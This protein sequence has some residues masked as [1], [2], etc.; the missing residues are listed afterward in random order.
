MSTKHMKKC[1]PSLTSLSIREMQAKAMLKFNLILEKMAI[2]RKSKQQMLVW[3][4]Q[5]RNHPTLLVGY[6]ALQ[7]LWESSRRC[8]KELKLGIPYDPATPLLSIFLEE[9]K[10]SYYS[11][12]CM[13]MFISEQSVK[14]RGREKK[15]RE[16]KW[17]R[18]KSCNIYVWSLPK[19]TVNC[20]NCKHVLTK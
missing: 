9:L 13:P 3:L 16:R 12:I 15:K 5:S 1:S 4:W 20:V 14:I 7:P 19:M 8:L 18:K 17:M 2:I 10:S 6:K 11:D